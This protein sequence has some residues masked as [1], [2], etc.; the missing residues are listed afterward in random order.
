M[1][2]CEDYSTIHSFIFNQNSCD[3]WERT[4]YKEREQTMIEPQLSDCILCSNCE[5]TWWTYKTKKSWM[6]PWKNNGQQIYVDV[7]VCTMRWSNQKIMTICKLPCWIWKE[8][9]CVPEMTW[10]DPSPMTHIL[11]LSFC[12]LTTLS[13]YLFALNAQHHFDYSPF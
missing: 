6:P 4:N 1:H 13:L 3:D 10:S 5:A 9:N 8:N 7:T 11:S 2:G 12:S